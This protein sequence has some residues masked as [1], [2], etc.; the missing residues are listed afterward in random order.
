QIGSAS[1]ASPER[2]SWLTHT[3]S[4]TT[5]TRC[6]TELPPDALACPACASLVHSDRLKHLAAAADA[7]ARAGSLV[8]A[9]NH[10][11]A[12]LRLLPANSQQH[13]AVRGRIADLTRRIESETTGAQQGRPVEAPSS[14]QSSPGSQGRSSE[15][16]VRRWGG[17]AGLG[18]VL[19]L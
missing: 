3:E 4:M 14:S 13:V 19:L 12:A 2:D 9:R 1:P 6:G 5:C 17:A 7:D 11:T 15:G 8:S 18:S 16:S 10:W